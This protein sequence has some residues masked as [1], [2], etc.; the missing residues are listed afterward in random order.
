MAD[1]R[2]LAGVW[3]AWHAEGPGVEPGAGCDKKIE[4]FSPFLTPPIIFIKTPPQSKG[5]RTQNQ[6]NDNSMLPM[7]IT[8]LSSA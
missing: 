2:G 7:G 1:G 3:L 8:H 6:I 5:Y 4:H